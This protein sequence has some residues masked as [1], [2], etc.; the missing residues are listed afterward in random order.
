MNLRL[1]VLTVLFCFQ[2]PEIGDFVLEKEECQD[3]N[4]PY[5]WR[6]KRGGLIQKYERMEEDGKVFYQNVLSVSNYVF[7]KV[8]MV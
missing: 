4:I 2:Q 8:I 5:L 1:F 3:G 6:Y 7:A